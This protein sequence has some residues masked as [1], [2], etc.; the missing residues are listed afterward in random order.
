M[1]LWLLIKGIN[2]TNGT[3]K[4]NPQPDQLTDEATPPPPAPQ[5]HR[6]PPQ[7]QPAPA[8][9]AA[10]TPSQEDPFA[11]IGTARSSRGIAAS[12]TATASVV[13]HSSRLPHPHLHTRTTTSIP[14]GN[15]RCQPRNQ[16]AREKN[17]RQHN[18]EPQLPRPVRP[19]PLIFTQ[20]SPRRTNNFEFGNLLHSH[21][22][23]LALSPPRKP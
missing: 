19:L 1:A 5:S 16:K 22:P 7:P 10:S 18:V 17:C 3:S 6:P 15:H 21:H 4:P 11:S 20:Q 9:P 14:H 13:H 23:M 12:Q 2:P 8:P